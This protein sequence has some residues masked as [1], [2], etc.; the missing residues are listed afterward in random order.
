MRSFFESTG[1]IVLKNKRALIVAGGTGGH[2][3]PGLAVAKELSVR[4]YEV[5]WLGTSLGIESK[6]VPSAGI[7]LHCLSVKG[8]RGRGLKGYFSAPLKIIESTIQAYRL[9]KQFKPV[10]V[11]GFGGYVAGPAG[12]ASR[13]ARV[14]LF[15]HEQNAVAGTTN[16]ILAKMAT[17]V[18]TAFPNIFEKAFWVGNPVRNELE[19][20]SPPEERMEKIPEKLNLLVL[21]GSRGALAINELVPR[22]LSLIPQNHFTIWHQTGANKKEAAIA[23]YKDVELEFKVEEF[24]EDME[25]AYRWAHIVVCRSGAL[26][27]SELAAIGL[28]SILIPFPFA[29]DDHQTENA[30]FLSGVGAAILIPQQDLTPEGLAEKLLDLVANR[31]RVLDMAVL[32][33]SKAKFG[34]AKKIADACEECFRGE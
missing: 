24:I 7:P 16:K 23:E 11:L 5:E 34:A 17:K 19:N 4:D 6:L 30:K 8:V 32:A 20:I 29:I 26:T 18:F 10:V 13:L 21:G 12:L 22:A 27:I 14:P 28:G 9:I 2:V 31:D 1:R 15:I 25:Q 3:F 33:N